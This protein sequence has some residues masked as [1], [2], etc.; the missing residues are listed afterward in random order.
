MQLR[1]IETSLL[2]INFFFFFFEAE[3]EKEQYNDFM[4]LQN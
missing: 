4:R 2:Y 3:E 1:K